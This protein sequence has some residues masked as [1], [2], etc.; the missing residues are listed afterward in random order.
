ME[1]AESMGERSKFHIKK[2]G[3]RIKRNVQL[4]KNEEFG[5]GTPDPLKQIRIVLIVGNRQ[6]FL[7]T[8]A[9]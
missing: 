9:D 2:R 5:K 7:L 4:E 1:T 3:A 8:D 6:K